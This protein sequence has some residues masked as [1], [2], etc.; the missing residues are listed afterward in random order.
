MKFSLS[1]VETHDINTRERQRPK[2][3]VIVAAWMTAYEALDT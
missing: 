2:T 3:K 1:Q